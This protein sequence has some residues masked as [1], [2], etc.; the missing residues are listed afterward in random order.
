[1]YYFEESA[2]NIVG[3]FQR[4]LQRFRAPIVIRHPGNNVPLAFLVTTLY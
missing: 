2:C 3:T 4:L 1:M